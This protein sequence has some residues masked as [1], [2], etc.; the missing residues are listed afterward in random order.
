MLVEVET[1][2]LWSSDHA[3]G[4][5][6]LM[7]LN[8]FI[9]GSLLTTGPSAAQGS[10]SCSGSEAGSSPTPSGAQVGLEAAIFQMKN[11]DPSPGNYDGNGGG[12]YT[13]RFSVARL[14]EITPSLHHSP[15][16]LGVVEGR[17]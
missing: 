2:S 6:P 8:N 15:T 13:A 3:R 11:K 7:G 1:A 14:D 5:R 9:S 4:S 10:V 12:T 16:A 17:Q